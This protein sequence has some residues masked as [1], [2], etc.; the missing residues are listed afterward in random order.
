MEDKRR[1]LFIKYLSDHK[2]MGI[3]FL[4]FIVSV[5]LKSLTAVDICIPCIW[6]TV[7]GFNCPGCGLTTALIDIL[8]MNFSAALKSNWLI[9]ILLPSGLYYIC[10][11]YRKYEK[12]SDIST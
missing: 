1:K 4:Y 2:V 11:D 3:V 8:K 6:K 7:F 9:F 10:W 5:I 12:I